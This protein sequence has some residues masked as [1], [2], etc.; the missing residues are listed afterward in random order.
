MKILFLDQLVPYPLDSG[1]KFRSYFMLRRLAAEHEVVLACFSRADNTAQQ[2]EHLRSFCRAVHVVPMTRS[3]ARD[4]RFLARSLLLGRSFIIERDTMLAMQELIDHLLREADTVGQP[5]DVIHCDQLWMAQYALRGRG[6]KKV[7]DQHNAVHLIPK[8]MAEH[9]RNPLKRRLL[10]R[11][12]RALARYEAAVCRQFERVIAVT[13]EDRRCLQ[14]LPGD[15]PLPI[16]VIP[17]CVDADSTPFLERTAGSQT[18]IH[19]GTMYWPPNVDGVLW[20]A[21]EVLPLVRRE[22]PGA[23]FIVAGKNPPPEVTALAADPGIAVTGYVADP[24]P[25]LEQSAA[26][27]APLRA[28]GGMRVKI[29]DGWLW[30]VP[31]VSTGIGAEGIE[32]HPGRDILIADT[33]QDFAAAV[34]RL[35]QDPALGRRLAEAG[36]RWAEARYDW[37]TAYAA[38][39]E[40]YGGLLER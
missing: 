9:E 35:M 10:E 23:R 17:I 20:F 21:R 39:S 13:E 36:R 19:L 38:L 2:I 3:R 6:I 25:W 22:M 7:L 37:R 12:A 28:G 34:V 16:T 24:R 33:P 40:L 31:I 8:R 5:F 11:E 4:A 30:G 29:P 18:A 1:V 32:C 27:L 15:G 26:F 14:A